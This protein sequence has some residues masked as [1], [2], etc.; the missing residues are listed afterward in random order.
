M[1]KANE[2]T[3]SLTSSH[4]SFDHQGIK[5]IYTPCATLAD[6]II[7]VEMLPASNVKT[8]LPTAR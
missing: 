3:Q 2:R 8:H 6:A 5:I 4:A 7:F 1:R